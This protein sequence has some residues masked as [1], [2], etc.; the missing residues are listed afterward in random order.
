[1]SHKLGDHRPLEVSSP[2]ELPQQDI[3]IDEGCEIEGKDYIVY[4]PHLK[5][6]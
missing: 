4:H 1:M 5:I 2:S 3:E 6:Y